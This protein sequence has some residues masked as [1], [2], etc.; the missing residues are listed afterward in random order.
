MTYKVHI[1]NFDKKLDLLIK[2]GKENIKTHKELAK[3]LEIQ[4]DYLSRLRS[5]ARPLSEGLI[6]KIAVEFNIELKTFYDKLDAFGRK[7]GLTRSQIS[8]MTGSPL[9]GIDF[10]SRIKDP[11]VVEGIYNVIKGFWCS[12][13]YSVSSSKER[14]ISRDL[15]IIDK[16]N[17]DL[18]IECRVID[19]AFSY[20][21]YCFPIR[22]HLYFILEKEN[23]F[24]EIIMYITN[25]PDREPPVLKGII[26]CISGGVHGVAA[27]PSAAKI[28]FKYLGYTHANIRKTF[29]DTPGERIEEY[30]VKNVP[31]YISSDVSD[32][33]ILDAID[34]QILHEDLPFALRMTD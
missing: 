29:P 23:L 31:Q 27:N 25:H 19:S 20:A 30:L 17:D 7:I 32:D 5:G 34:N 24:N 26:L 22:G 14:V 33:Y 4:P 21:G 6:A 12:Y 15:I 3:R 11:N 2:S 10:N 9:P 16:V 1:E 13:Y 28:I 8:I 18:F